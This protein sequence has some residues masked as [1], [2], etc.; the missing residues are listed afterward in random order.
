M[1]NDSNSHIV[2]YSFYFKI[3][4]ALIVLTILTVAVTSV[5]LGPLTVAVALLIAGVKSTLVLLY[6]MH[7]KF[8][9]K[10]YGLMVGG[11]I[12]VFIAVL[13][14]TFLDFYYRYNS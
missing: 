8:D 7:L 4:L 13:A 14:V 9:N 1:S 10:I 6:F 2:K 12:L 3:L 11:V 5:E